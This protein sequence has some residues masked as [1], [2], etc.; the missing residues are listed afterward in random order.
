MIK[1]CAGGMWGVGG[2]P[3]YVFVMSVFTVRIL[4]KKWANQ[5]LVL[6]KF[7][8]GSHQG[9]LQV[10]EWN[11]VPATCRIQGVPL[12]CSIVRICVV[13]TDY[14][15]KYCISATNENDRYWICA[16]VLPDTR[17]LGW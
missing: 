17:T 15:C 9:I 14:T 6:L 10:G 3:K 11:L 12:Q 16:A 1:V 13:I 8:G 5:F 7:E 4:G 2:M